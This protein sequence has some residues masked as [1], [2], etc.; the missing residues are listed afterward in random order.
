MIKTREDRI[1][2]VTVDVSMTSTIEPLMA[3]L[4]SEGNARF[5]VS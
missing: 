1:E 3:K 5:K 4:E 2:H